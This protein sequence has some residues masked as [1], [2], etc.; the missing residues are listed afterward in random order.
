MTG[1]TIHTATVR[2][3]QASVSEAQLKFERA[4]DAAWHSGEKVGYMRGFRSKQLSAGC[5]GFLMGCLFVVFWTWLGM[6]S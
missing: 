4:V 3:E 1:T 2:P 6:V 5:I